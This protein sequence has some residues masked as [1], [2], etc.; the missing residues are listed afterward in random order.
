M[1]DILKLKVVHIHNGFLSAD[2]IPERRYPYSFGGKD[3]HASSA[4]KSQSGHTSTTNLRPDLIFTQGLSE[5][6]VEKIKV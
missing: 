1:Q 3:D 6:K 5:A 4:A 2:S